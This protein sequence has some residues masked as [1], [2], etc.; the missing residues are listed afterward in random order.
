MES[1][2]FF[3]WQ[4]LFGPLVQRAWERPNEPNQV[5]LV[6]WAEKNN[7]TGPVSQEFQAGQAEP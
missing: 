1:L 2:L 6:A 3:H 7:A 5:W 4:L